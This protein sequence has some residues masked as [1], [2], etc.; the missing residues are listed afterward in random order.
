MTLSKGKN[1]NQ[2]VLSLR[3]FLFLLLAISPTTL[4]GIALS[5][6]P[7]PNLPIPP[8]PFMQ[9]L[10]N[11]DFEILSDKR[12]ES[13]I[14][15]ARKWT[16]SFPNE[17]QKLTVKWKVGKKVNGEGWNNTPRREVA[18]FYLQRLFLDPPDYVVPPTTVRCIPLAKY[19]KIKPK[20]EPNIEDF[21]CV[22]GE[23][24]AW[25]QNV[26]NPD[27][28][29]D[30][31]RFA[32][33]PRYAYFFANL[34]LFCYL[35]NHQDGTVDNFFISTVP[36]SPRFFSYDNGIGFKWEFHNFFIHNWNDIKV[37]A[38]PRKTIDRLR[39]VTDADLD[40]LGVVEQLDPD[41]DGVLRQVEPRENLS[42]NTGAR[43]RSNTLQIGLTQA[44]I[45][46]LKKR[47]HKLL[48]EV[49]QGKWPLF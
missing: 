30:P 32:E 47:L 29:Y 3:C 38:L 35:I 25:L 28:T 18:A 19:Q 16:V 37:L 10:K 46:E 11:A 31:K 17:P 4:S 49:D 7:D 2:K 43:V 23:L 22:Y 33:D 27:P 9:L 36:D 21:P 40:R 24:Q 41:A 34:N 14:S 44:E 1:K 6:E 45:E 5:D 39:Q 8:E 48:K 26:K 12:T 20:A 15:G 13:G 42:P